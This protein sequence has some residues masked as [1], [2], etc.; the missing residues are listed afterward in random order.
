MAIKRPPVKK[1]KWLVFL[2]LLV[3]IAPPAG[4]YGVR[5]WR[6]Y[7]THVTTDDAYVQAD[8]AQIT[9]RISG[10]VTK[11]S[12]DNNWRVERG[13]VL[14][15]LDPRDYEVQL[16]EARANLKKARETIR[17]LTESARAAEARVA[18]AKAQ[19]AQARQDFARNRELFQK[20]LISAETFDHAR[21]AYE[22]TSAQLDQA[23]RELSQAIAALGGD[24]TTPLDE[25]AIVQQALAAVQAATLNLSYCTIASP[26]QGWVTQK[27]VQVGQAVQPGQQ[28]MAVVPLQAIYVE[29][30]YKETALTDVRVGQPVE[31][32]ADIYPGTVFRGRVDSLS[33][34][35]GAAFSLLPPEN[36]TGNW[37]KVVQRVPVKIVLDQPLPPDRPLR[38]GL[39]VVTTIDTT[40]R[41]G[42]LLISLM[43]TEA[44]R[45]AAQVHPGERSSG[46]FG[47]TPSINE[48][49]RNTIGNNID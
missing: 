30:N 21:A 46:D 28:L 7:A 27:A 31:V 16:A 4:Y 43:Q 39:S 20:Q 33:A 14:V 19:A 1:K 35:T 24:L 29:A 44:E 3:L 11:V 47:I 2:I 23:K 22:T 42:P 13:Q 41:H 38:I 25:H 37:V 9:P 36:A 48:R 32:K 18:V 34:G 6:Y 15:Q 5:F 17:E 8:T 40:D 45:K 12:V 10:T 26:L 49:E